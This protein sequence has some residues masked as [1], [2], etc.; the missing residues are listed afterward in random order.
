MDGRRE[1]G[2][3]SRKLIERRAAEL[4]SLVGL[5]GVSLGLLASDLGMPKSSIATLYGTTRELQ[6]AAVAVAVRI[7]AEQVVEPA[8]TAPPGSQRLVALVDAWVDYVRRRVFPGGSFMVATAAEFDSRPGPV[9]DALARARR[10]WIGLLAAQAAK[11]Q[12][13]GQLTGLPPDLV[14]FEIDAVLASACVAAN[15]LDDPAALDG[16]RRII[17]HR[18]AT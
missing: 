18:L 16:A 9:R 12:E 4:A 1:R 14:A 17:G 6:L 11:A 15:L 3:R 13:Y 10:D 5:E 8:A 2:D 7:F